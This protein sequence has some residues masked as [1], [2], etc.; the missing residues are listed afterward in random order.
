[1]LS[2]CASK[3]DSV[4][5]GEFPM[6]STIVVTSVSPP[7]SSLQA[8]ADGARARGMD[9]LVM[10]DTKS[11][12]EF[13]LEGCE[14]YDVARQG[15]TGFK[16][17][18]LCPTRSYARKN[19]GYL[20]SIA[21]RAPVILETDDDNIP[22]ESFWDERQLNIEAPRLASAGWVNVYGYFTDAILW[23]R[24]LPLDAVQ[25]SLPDFDSLT[26]GT[27]ECPIQQGLADGDPDVDA[28]YRL[29]L[30]LPQTFRTDRRV[31]LDP[32]SWCPFNSQNTT[33][34]P[35][36]YPLMYLPAYCSFRMTDIWG[37][38]VAQRIAWANG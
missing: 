9:F 28:I 14:F 21:G 4:I 10:G 3:A 31:I 2:G 36:V 37:S 22:R 25:A 18:K 11:P 35:Q 23:P 38:F 7:N 16:Y 33:W 29:I 13:T 17:A 30:P 8:L 1:M 6:P 34:F 27:S 12:A 32:G 26:S 5:G 24:G 19:I 15:E 20:I